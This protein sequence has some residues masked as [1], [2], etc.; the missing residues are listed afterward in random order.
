MR[1]RIDH[2][3]VRTGFPFAKT[4]HEVHLTVDFTHEEKQIIRQRGLAEHELLERIPADARVDDDPA[5]FILKVGHLFERR[6]DKFRCK[7]PSDAK[8]YEQ[9]L[10]G[11]LHMMKAW[12]DE[13]AETGTTTVI[14]I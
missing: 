11:A 6:P 5:W 3:E 2:E 9:N 7:T 4:F 14:E 13:N 12:L 8:I 1:I 10:I